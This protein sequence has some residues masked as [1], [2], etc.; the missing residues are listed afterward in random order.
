M[1]EQKFFDFTADKKSDWI[2][3]IA[4]EQKGAGKSSQAEAMLW[5]AIAVDLFYTKEDLPRA[6][7]QHEFHPSSALPGS[8]A[9]VWSTIIGIHPQDEKKDNQEILNALENGAEGL[10]LH[11]NGTENLNHL[12]HGVKTEY[13]QL[14]FLPTG[15]TA[16]VLNQLRD[17]L[18]SIN[19]K[20]SMLKG[21]YLWNPIDALFAG[22]STLAKEV[23]F[24][25]ESIAL[26]REFPEFRPLTLDLAKY[27][28]T[29]A[30]GLQQLTYG[31]GEMIELVD[32]LVKRGVSARTL[33][34]KAAFRL[35]VGSSH[36]AEIAKLKA[37]RNLISGLA[38]TIGVPLQTAEIQLLVSTSSFSKSFLDKHT[39]MIRQ[40]YEAMAAILG[41]ANAV[42]VKPMNEQDANPL[43]KRIARNIPTILR[44]E[45]YLDKVMDPA[46]GSYYLENLQ[47]DIEKQVIQNLQDLEASG[48]WMKS[49][50]ENTLHQAIRNTRTLAQRDILEHKQILVGVNKYQSGAPLKEDPKQVIIEEKEH[51]LLPSRAA[52]MVELEILNKK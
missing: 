51:E 46:A 40:S 48:G 11:L 9:R 17:W 16:L 8:S 52:Y 44:D 14:Y 3:R 32:H 23:N 25:I 5:D 41:G 43:E 31:L 22:S 34:E 49:F 35:A 4:K 12:L 42:W 6:I 30:S 39:N 29:G 24:T 45:S 47:Y 15:E 27:A 1:T 2:A 19:L 33:F 36:F 26:F 20:P 21:A 10:V 37:F 13:I 28:D 7:Q 18:H 38:H 50:E